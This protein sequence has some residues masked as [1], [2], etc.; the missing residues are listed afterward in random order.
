MTR[1]FVFIGVTT[2]ESSMMRIF[3]RWR[4]ALGLD[5]EVELVGRDLPIHAPP[6]QY[7]ETV[8]WLREEPDNV[9]ALVT[10]HKIDLYHAARDL[11]DDVDDYAQLLGEVSC[12]ARRDG[13]LLGWATDPISAGRALEEILG[14]DYFSRTGG[15]VLCFGAGG[16]GNAITLYMLTELRAEEQPRRIIVTDPDPE[17]LAMLEALHSRLDSG[18]HVEY[19]RSGDAPVGDQLVAGLR[20]HSLVINATGMGKDRPGSP[21][22]D[23]VRFP[24]EGI[25]W[26]L[27]YRGELRFLH[28]AWKQRDERNLRVED[29]WA[30]FIFGWTTVMEK[31][32]QRPITAGELATLA[33]AA[34][35]ARPPLPTSD[36]KRVM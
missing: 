4:D 23:D 19:I 14:P 35:F 30:Y 21:V 6:E 29:G 15:E 2:G 26:E 13:R 32:F 36:P 34:A 28:T 18:A 11:F 1:R 7:R 31:V 25:A 9:G 24:R 12:I 20:D 16:A 10:T 27:N 3:P 5:P 33:D 17:R 8:A 22:S